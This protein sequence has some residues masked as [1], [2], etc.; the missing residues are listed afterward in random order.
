MAVTR[1]PKAS[2]QAESTVDV[3]ALI[4]KGGAVAGQETRTAKGKDKPSS[5]ILRI[6]PQL[7]ERIELARQERPV[8]IPRHTWLLEAVVEKLDREKKISE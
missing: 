6:P 3:D 5:V 8:R 1:K 4:R 7:L 2:S